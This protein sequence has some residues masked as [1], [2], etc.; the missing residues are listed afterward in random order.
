M[1]VR[2]R[3]HDICTPA[4]RKNKGPNIGREGENHT[5]TYIYI[6]IHRFTFFLPQCRTHD[7]SAEKQESQSTSVYIHIQKQTYIQCIYPEIVWQ[8][9][10]HTMNN[11]C[12]SSGTPLA[13]RRGP[14]PGT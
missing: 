13:V 8:V 9:Y 10:V 5:Y 4:V 2:K 11:T 3:I 12:P 1:H 14:I 6:H 7:R